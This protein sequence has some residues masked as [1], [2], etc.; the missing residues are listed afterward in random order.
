MYNIGLL[1]V[2]HFLQIGYFMKLYNISNTNII[3]YIVYQILQ[4]YLQ[5][6][7]H[8]W[9]HTLESNKKNHFGLFLWH[10]M[11]F[12][13]KIHLISSKIH[14]IHH[15]H[16]LD[17]LNDVEIWNDLYIPSFMNNCADNIFRYLIQ[18]NIENSYKIKL[19]KIIQ[20]FVG[21]V[22]ILSFTYITI[23]IDKLIF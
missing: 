8:L 3:I 22:A 19:Y 20:F 2:S 6:I 4:I 15:N 18:L 14:K 5:A 17:N 11:T 16:N 7:T 1:R 12:L 21:C 13:E 10:V 23:I 9:Y